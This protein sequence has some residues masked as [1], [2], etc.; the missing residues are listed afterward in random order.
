M[1]LVTS[2]DPHTPFLRGVYVLA[3]SFSELS[4]SY[5][6]V[7]EFSHDVVEGTTLPTCSENF[8]D[9]LLVEAEIFTILEV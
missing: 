1:V 4:D 6:M 3:N 5:G 7:I 8:C 9:N 2:L